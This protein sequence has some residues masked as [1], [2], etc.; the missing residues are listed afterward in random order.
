MVV[1]VGLQLAAIAGTLKRKASNQALASQESKRCR[2]T[3]HQ[4]GRSAQVLAGPT[5][6][7]DGPRDSP[8]HSQST[9]GGGRAKGAPE[10]LCG[11]EGRSSHSS[12]G[13]T[14]RVPLAASDVAGALF[15]CARDA[16]LGS[17]SSTRSPT[18][19]GS[20]HQQGDT[21]GSSRQD[22]ARSLRR[23]GEW[24]EGWGPAG[25]PGAGGAPQ[26]QH[27][28]G[29]AQKRSSW[30]TS[31]SS[32][33]VT[34]PRV[35]GGASTAA[36]L[37][38]SPGAKGSPE[39]VP[40][41][42][43]QM[44]EACPA[45]GAPGAPHAAA[46]QGAYL[47]Q[48]AF[49][50]PESFI[51]TPD[52]ELWEI[53][54]P[55]VAC[56]SDVPPSRATDRPGVASS[57]SGAR[58]SAALP[59]DHATT[60]DG[61]APHEH[62]GP[63][64]G[65]RHAP[66]AQGQQALSAGCGLP[67]SGGHQG[68]DAVGSPGVAYRSRGALRTASK[69]QSALPLPAA[70]GAH[71]LGPRA[72]PSA[73]ERSIPGP[74]AEANGLAPGGT[75]AE[76]HA[77]R[78]QSEKGSLSSGA[79]E[80][81]DDDVILLGAGASVCLRQGLGSPGST[82]SSPAPLPA[83]EY[84]TGAQFLPPA[85]HRP[86]P[87]SPRPASTGSRAEGSMELQP[88]HDG[89]VPAS[90]CKQA[91]L[92]R[93]VPG[94]HAPWCL[95][96]QGSSFLPVGDPSLAQQG[97]APDTVEQEVSSQGVLRP[98]ASPLAV[99]LTEARQTEGGADPPSP[100]PAGP[101]AAA[102]TLGASPCAGRQGALLG[103]QAVS[104][105]AE[106]GS[107]EMQLAEQCEPQEQALQSPSQPLPKDLQEAV[108][109][110]E[111]ASLGQRLREFLGGSS[112]EEGSS[113]AAVA[114][115][116][117]VL[118]GWDR[119]EAGQGS[120]GQS[121]GWRAEGDQEQ[122]GGQAH[123]CVPHADSTAAVHTHGP[124]LAAPTAAAVQL[125]QSI[126]PPLRASA[127]LR[128]GS[129]LFELPPQQLHECLA[130]P[131]IPSGTSERDEQ[132]DSPVPQVQQTEQKDCPDA[133]HQ[134][135]G[136]QW[137]DSCDLRVRGVR[138]PSPTVITFLSEGPE[139]ADSPSH[140]LRSSHSPAPSMA[141]FAPGH[142]M[143]PEAGMGALHGDGRM[144]AERLGC[145]VGAREVGHLEGVPSVSVPGVGLPFD[146]LLPQ[147]QTAMVTGMG[148]QATSFECE[149]LQGV[150]SPGPFAAGESAHSFSSTKALFAS[151]EEQSSKRLHS[152]TYSKD[153]ARQLVFL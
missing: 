123:S 2:G 53:P 133:L 61:P 11:R 19:L 120:R 144:E 42:P 31:E 67:E 124:A 111:E 41:S 69:E 108:Q 77:P 113:G 107:A 83:T 21:R 112:S 143:N 17:P 22:S 132:I 130:S 105:G 115:Q 9:A 24:G 147:G 8:G 127:T 131:G 50:D 5:E 57:T 102:R 44:P 152:P 139:K 153:S 71:L 110:E 136:S 39:H 78:A 134:S 32:P 92:G 128:L 58:A 109:V 76:E 84:I 138:T 141:R 150:L 18:D 93:A 38:D 82:S 96:A 33:G 98:Q 29:P 20:Q 106:W 116:G 23:R 51:G 148:T 48:G 91:S 6:V 64:G 103:Q 13:S 14:R 90:Q 89:Q 79:G 142:Q 146:Y 73:R 60:G 16:N 56:A 94:R 40:A 35:A 45:P 10:T 145:G 7:S 27:S 68:R 74:P 95:P 36:G 47:E 149:E 15:Q 81:G 12:K 121:A 99:P 28:R 62:R 55:T 129:L 26:G 72:I 43:H 119:T 104:Y 66:G 117:D 70:C 97:H 37:A 54:A 137:D 4:E 52:D 80:E 59:W 87:S 126:L 25:E 49:L 86:A 88:V 151:V 100:G 65:R 46:A 85:H 122:G 125:G 3:W 63:S 140:F 1:L 75:G 101:A 34:L 30:H 118:S 135:Q 114:G